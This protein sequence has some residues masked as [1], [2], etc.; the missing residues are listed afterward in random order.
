MFKRQGVI[1]KWYERPIDAG[2]NVTDEL[3][4]VGA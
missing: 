4:A 2:A 1:D 3:M